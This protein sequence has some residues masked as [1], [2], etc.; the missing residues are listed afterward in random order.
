MF[1]QHLFSAVP[2]LDSLPQVSNEQQK[3]SLV[4]ANIDAERNRFRARTIAAAKEDIAAHRA[5][6][7]NTSSIEASV[8]PASAVSPATDS[9]LARMLASLNSSTRSPI[10]QSP[11]QMT[12]NARPGTNA[13]PQASTPYEV[14]VALRTMHE[15]KRYDDVWGPQRDALKASIAAAAATQGAN[16]MGETNGGAATDPRRDLRRQLT[17][18]AALTNGNARVAG[19][20]VSGGGDIDRDRDPRRR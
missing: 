20:G 17:G 19:A 11:A 5:R 10:Q 9:G 3:L 12:P 2:D 1:Q 15:L 4:L 13:V 7:R 16:G 6:H 8:S 14:K 18:A